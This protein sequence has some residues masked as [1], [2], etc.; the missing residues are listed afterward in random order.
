MVRGS[1][2]ERAAVVATRRAR[3]KNPPRC[4]T[5]RL[6]SPG[7]QKNIRFQSTCPFLE[8]RAPKCSSHRII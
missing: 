3:A 8:A 6:T 2:R 7:N 4:E 5:P 1:R